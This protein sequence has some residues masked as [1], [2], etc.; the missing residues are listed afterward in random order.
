MDCT[1]ESGADLISE[2]LFGVV[3]KP[4]DVD[5]LFDVV[6]CVVLV[7]GMQGRTRAGGDVI[8]VCA[9]CRVLD[10]PLHEGR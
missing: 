1:G 7:A 6:C 5:D 10:G 4:D 9:L 8:V 2:V 3:C